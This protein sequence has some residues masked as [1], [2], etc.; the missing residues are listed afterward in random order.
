MALASP[1]VSLAKRI[2]K[3]TIRTAARVAAVWLRPKKTHMVY[4]RK[5]TGSGFLGC[6]I[7]MLT[8]AVRTPG[9]QSLPLF[10]KEL[11][12]HFAKNYCTGSSIMH[13]QKCWH[14][15]NNMT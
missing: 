1:V 14:P 9:H 4:L 8:I 6:T 15:G 12:M 3:S 10:E 13:K 5:G 7:H 11:T 2:A